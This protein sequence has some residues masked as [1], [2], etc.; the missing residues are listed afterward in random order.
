M[1]PIEIHQAKARIANSTF[2]SN[3]L[4]GGGDRS[5]RGALD[6]AVIYIRG[7]QPPF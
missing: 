6:A 3:R 5:G 4:A 1:D 2:Q 7:A